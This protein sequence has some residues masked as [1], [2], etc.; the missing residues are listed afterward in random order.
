MPPPQHEKHRAGTTILLHFQ[1]F[2]TFVASCTACF[3]ASLFF[4]AKVQNASTTEG[5]LG[6]DIQRD[7]VVRSPPT[8]I[9]RTQ[10]STRGKNGARKRGTGGGEYV[11]RGEKRADRCTKSTEERYSRRDAIG[12]DHPTKLRGRP[13]AEGKDVSAPA[14]QVNRRG[15]HCV[16]GGGEKVTTASADAI[17]TTNTT[18]DAVAGGCKRQDAEVAK[19]ANKSETQNGG[20]TATEPITKEAAFLRVGEDTEGG[21]GAMLFPEFVEALTRLCLARYGPLAPQTP[22]AASAAK[23]GGGTVARGRKTPA[24]GGGTVIRIFAS[25]RTA[26]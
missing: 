7:M 1:R 15:K 19:P 26:S 11:S 20:D 22:T 18:G 10:K 25:V 5:R 23:K 12:A 24:F 8:G 3:P 2:R 13:R 6:L 17:T 9:P 14:L 4:F 16:A 21:Q